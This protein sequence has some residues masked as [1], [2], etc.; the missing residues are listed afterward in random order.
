MRLIVGGY[1]LSTASTL[2]IRLFHVAD[3]GLSTIIY[4]DVLDAHKLL[5]E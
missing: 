4:V 5:P 2:H 3:D 1:A